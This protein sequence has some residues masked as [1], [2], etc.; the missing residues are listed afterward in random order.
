[1]ANT[2]KAYGGDKPVP[3]QRAIPQSPG[4]TPIYSTDVMNSA[5]QNFLKFANVSCL[6][7]ARALD[8]ET[9]LRVNQQQIYAT[10]QVGQY[11]F[12]PAVDGTFVPEIPSLLLAQGRFGKD[13]SVLAGRNTHE[14]Y[15]FTSPVDKDNTALTQNL[16]AVFPGINDNATDYILNTLYPAVFDGSQPYINWFQRAAL[17]NTELAFICNDYYMVSAL[18]HTS[19]GYQYAIAP[20]LH[21]QDVPYT[22]YSGQ[23]LS[24]PFNSTTSFAAPQSKDAALTLQD[25][26]VSFVIDGKPVTSVMGSPNLPVWGEG[27]EIGILNVTLSNVFTPGLVPDNAANTRCKWWQEA[28]YV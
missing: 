19:Y 28:L 23:P 2:L 7:E 15:L 8:T 5:Y 11:T 27:G 1:M 21:G 14:G 17:I 16:E 18:P 10:T 12:G 26:I 3:F 9:L 25:W 13:I 6:E 22:F 4:F 24:S 20:A